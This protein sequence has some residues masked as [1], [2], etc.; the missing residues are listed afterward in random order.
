VV[1]KYLPIECDVLGRSL[2]YVSM[3]GI[4]G[5]LRR[6]GQLIA[7]EWL[8]GIDARIAYRGPDGAGRFRDR[9][10]E[11]EIALVH[12]RLSII[13]HDT[14]SQPM[15]SEC[16]RDDSEGLVAVV[17]NGCIYNHRDLRQQ[18]EAEGH[19]FKTDHSDTES[20]IHA[21]RQWGPALTDHLEGMYAFALWDHD[22]QS[23][24]LARDWF[25]EKPLY[26]RV[27]E[28]DQSGVI[29]FASDAQALGTLWQATT[30]GNAARPRPSW[31]RRYLQLGYAHEGV[32]V[33]DDTRNLRPSIVNHMDELIGPLNTYKARPETTTQAQFESL[34]AQAVHQ[35]LEA[36]VPLGCFLSGGVDSSLIAYFAKQHQAD[37]R[38]F[39]VRM[40]DERYDESHHAELVADHLGTNHTTLEVAIDPAEDLQHLIT[41]LG[42]PFGDSSILP[43]YW[44]SKAAR[45]HVQVALSGDGGDE[46]FIGYER[47]AAARHLFR[48]RRLLQWF[49]RRWMR[50]THPKSFKHK[51]GRLGDM[52]RQIKSL[53]VLSMETIFTQH[54]IYD[55]MHGLHGTSAHEPPQRDPLQALRRADLMNY[56]PDDLL[57][58]VDTASMAVTNGASAVPLE[59]RCPFLDR[60]LVGAALAAP[61]SQLMPGG[62]SASRKGLLREIARKYLPD[63]IVD[64]PKMGFAIP[65]GEW[66]RN[67]FGNMQT[68]LL[69]HLNDRKLIESLLLNFD[70]VQ[71]MIDEHMHGKVDHGQRLFT[72]LTLTMWAR[73]EGAGYRG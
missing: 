41:T 73:G 3:C 10:G 28:G 25:G 68:L 58:K 18:L 22:K 4:G 45:Q 21:Y 17:F 1:K 14:G 60:E 42:Q 49:P 29:A 53:G 69:E 62:R 70:A 54:Q 71:S 48:H 8:D 2:L 9:S 15:V 34:I 61:T 20:L 72:L 59:V 39:T 63:D 33:Y 40:P 56:L 27:G 35:R 37:L 30:V 6:D 47:Y 55:L 57:C 32:T 19:T 43:T 13:D 66:F 23:L 26:V 46:L 51:L 67:D 7:D 50:S 44:V 38:T 52:A 5:I 11:I 16:G 24:V 65:V 12:R 64:R 36:D 31:T